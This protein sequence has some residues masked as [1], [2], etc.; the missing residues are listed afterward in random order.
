MQKTTLIPKDQAIFE[1]TKKFIEEGGNL[2]VV[3][4]LIEEANTDTKIFQKA[5]ELF[6]NI[7]KFNK[8]KKLYIKNPIKAEKVIIKIL[9]K[10]QNE[11]KLK[12]IPAPQK[13]NQL[14]KPQ[15]SSS[16]TQKSQL[17]SQLSTP[18]T[19]Y[20]SNKELKQCI[21]NDQTE[22]SK[23]QN[24]LRDT[25]TKVATIA[26]SILTVIPALIWIINQT[27]N[28]FHNREMRHIRF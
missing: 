22:A 9:K 21:I 19:P 23:T 2:K 4:Q 3:K 8:W 27:Q 24:T 12:K 7:Q 11:D 5:K 14:S 10:M 26:F 16:K 20:I 6:N 1:D 25:L 15:P 18:P 13:P 17:K 28:Y